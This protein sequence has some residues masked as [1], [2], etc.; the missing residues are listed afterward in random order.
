VTHRRLVKFADPKHQVGSAGHLDGLR[1]QLP[2]N[3]AVRLLAAA[4]RAE[5]TCPDAGA[6][7]IT[8]GFRDATAGDAG[9]RSAT[10]VQTFSAGPNGSVRIP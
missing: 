10:T 1:I 8:V 6:L 4:K 7:Q 9:N 5:M 2:A 3:G